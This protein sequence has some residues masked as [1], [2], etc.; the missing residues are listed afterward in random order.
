MF[1]KLRYLKD[2][3]YLWARVL[4]E[5]PAVQVFRQLLLALVLRDRPAVQV[6]RRVPLVLAH[7]A[8]LGP[9]L[10]LAIRE[11]LLY[12]PRHAHLQA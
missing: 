12:Q 7:H 8:V 6:A 3:H 10:Y 4:R 5:V 9:H 1:L 2:M 11:H